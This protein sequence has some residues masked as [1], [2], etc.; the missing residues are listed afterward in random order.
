[1]QGSLELLR[2][3]LERVQRRIGDACAQSGR[4]R[5]AVLLVAVTKYAQ[6]PWVQA[7]TQCDVWDLGESRP[8][9]LVARSAELQ[10]P[11]RWHMIGQLQRNKVRPVLE[12]ATL[13]HSVDSLRLLERIS[14][15]AGERAQQQHVLLEVNVSGESNKTGFAASELEAQWKQVQ[16]YDN[17]VIEGLMTMAP[18]VDD[19]QQARPYFAQLR[20]LRDRIVE[21]HAV[22][23][24]LPQLSMG[25][26][27]DFEAAIL[28]GATMVRIGSLLYEGLESS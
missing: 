28:E 16:A 22:S 25:M 9:Q 19:P 23:N 13:I 17:V 11:I 4:D 3:N 10:G 24:G 18:R 6:L 15:I 2:S 12:R 21:S 5:S 27:G 14:R 7:L 20:Q 26:S 8:Q 1:M